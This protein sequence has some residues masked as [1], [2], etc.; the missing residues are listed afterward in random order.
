[1]EHNPDNGGNI[2]N[3]LN[4]PQ[5]YQGTFDG[6]CAYYTGA[7]MLS[8]LFPEY[9][10]EF[11]QAK[12][13]RASKNMS[14]DP[15]FSDD[16]KDDR[17]NLSRWFYHGRNIKDVVNILN[18]LMK[19]YGKST[20]FKL[21]PATRRDSTF[22]NTIRNSINDGLPAMLGWDTE[23]YGLHAVL[24]T[25]YWIGKERWLMINDPGGLEQVSWESLKRQ[26]KGRGKFEV[27]LCVKHRGPRPMKT[28]VKRNGDP[29]VHIWM[30]EQVYIPLNELF[31]ETD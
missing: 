28:V 27:G 2:V 11:G 8:A 26:Q 29:I 15:F 30:P 4:V 12:G 22:N 25:G 17:N 20:Q 5:Y 13:Q 23:D 14:M 10:Q 7:M 6:L 24:V 16:K 31:F 19:K 3:L 9:S 1:M 18:G 21:K